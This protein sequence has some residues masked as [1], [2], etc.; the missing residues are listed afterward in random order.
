MFG[1]FQG[2]TD[3]VQ[4]AIIAALI[5]ALVVTAGAALILQLRLSDARVSEA[6]AQVEAAK[7]LRDVSTLKGNLFAL[8]SALARC[9]DSVKTA[10]AESDARLAKSEEALAAAKKAAAAQNA[11]ADAILAMARPQP[12][13]ACTTALALYRAERER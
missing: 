6:K 8:E 13:K 9:A 11:K 4:K 7:A 1:W 3:A 12:E 10:K 2:L 5:A